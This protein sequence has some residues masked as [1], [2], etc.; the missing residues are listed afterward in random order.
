MFGSSRYSIGT[1]LTKDAPGFLQKLA[2]PGMFLL[3]PVNRR[4]SVLSAKMKEREDGNL[5]RG[6]PAIYQS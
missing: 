5:A 1:T 4:V 6:A 2:A 3:F